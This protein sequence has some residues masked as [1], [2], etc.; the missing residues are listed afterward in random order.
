MLCGKILF[1]ISCSFGLASSRV[2]VLMMIVDWRNLYGKLLARH[3]LHQSTPFHLHSVH[4]CPTS[5]P[6][7]I[8]SV[9][10]TGPFG[11][12]ILHHH[13][14]TVAFKMIATIGILWILFGS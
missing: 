2:S 1:Q 8:S 6:R 11:R 10:R 9:Q 7:S 3:V 13:F 12:S 4:R 14:C 5:L